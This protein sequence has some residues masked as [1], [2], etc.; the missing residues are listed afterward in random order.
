MEK[1]LEKS[2]ND[3]Q[4]KIPAPIWNDKFNSYSVPD[5]QRKHNLSIFKENIMKILTILQ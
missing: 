5:I 3:N 4:C 2:Y 1:H